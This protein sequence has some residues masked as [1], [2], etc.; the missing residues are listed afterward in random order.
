M[1]S[2]T[3]TETLLDKS[4]VDVDILMEYMQRINTMG[5]SAKNQFEERWMQ[6]LG[7]L[8]MAPPS[9]GLEPEEATSL[10]FNAHVDC[11]HLHVHV[12][13]LHNSD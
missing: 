4:L 9:E 13:W 7:V 6:L 3:V 8:N 1:G 12:S 10:N 2:G 5:W 11:R